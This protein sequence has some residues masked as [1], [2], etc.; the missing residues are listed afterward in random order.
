MGLGLR[1]HWRRQE[2]I[3]GDDRHVGDGRTVFDSMNEDVFESHRPALLALAY[4]MLGDVGRAEDAVQESWV[5]WQRRSVEVDSPRAF[6]LT[7]VTRLCL[8]ELD[9]ARARHEELRS[10]RLPEPVALEE[11]GLSR[12]ERLD[13]ISMA[14]VVLLQRL[15]PAERAVF[16]LHEVFDLSHGEIASLLDRTEASSRQLLRRARDHVAT[17]KAIFRT[18]TEEHRRLLGAFVQA[19]ADGDRERLT[20]LL[21]S[22]ATALVDPGVGDRRFGKL[23]KVTAPVVGIRRVTALMMGFAKEAESAPIRQIPTTL[24]GEP[25]LVTLLEGRPIAAIF[26]SVAHGRIR[27]I[28]V[29]TDPSALSH[30]GSMQ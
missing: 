15:T 24:N 1:P 25:A 26:L 28:F 11:T 29:Q 16:L 12:V 2:P 17:E 3:S 21:A 4:R 10:D 5:R 27:H 19:I 20:G 18:S 13:S 8:D 7:I 14:F 30:L 22:D 6:L 23:R 9:S